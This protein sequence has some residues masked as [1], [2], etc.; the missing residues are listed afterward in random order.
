VFSFAVRPA[1]AWYLS[2]RFDAT[3]KYDY[4]ADAAV[5]DPINP[6]HVFKIG[7]LLEENRMF[8]DAAARFEDALRHDPRDYIYLLHTARA[9]AGENDLKSA[10]AYYD[11]AL[12]ANPYRAFTYSE[13]ANFY[14]KSQ[15]DPATALVLFK[16]AV[17]LEPDYAEARH[18]LALLFMHNGMNSEALAEFNAIE[19][20]LSANTP[21]TDYEKAL[22]SLPPEALYFNKASLL[23]N[24]ANFTES[25]YYYRK[26]FEITKDPETKKIMGP[27][28]AK[29]AKK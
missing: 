5:L 1:L 9:R 14:L 7:L 21:A 15:N 26:S 10:F 13:L 17:E 3:K 18:S 24:M 28:C 20:I 16:K 25:C 8:R 12:A 4:I 27:V 11:R 2:G 6:E 23:K 22:L 29:G 19:D